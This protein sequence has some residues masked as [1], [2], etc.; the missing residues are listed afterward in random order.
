M[1]YEQESPFPSLGERILQEAEARA[2]EAVLATPRELL[3]GW[4]LLPGDGITLEADGSVTLPLPPD[5]LM[6]FCVR[7]S[8]WQ[9]AVYE[10]LPAGSWL[11]R[12][13]GSRWLGL[14]GVPERPLAFEQPAADGGKCLKL[15]SAGAGATDV[16]VTEGWY[17]PAPQITAAGE[18]EIPPAAYHKTLGLIAEAIRCG[19]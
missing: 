10:V 5:Y 2:A 18:I 8:G 14:R 19:A 15:F 13:Q 7:L 9:R 3:T 17:M 16:G 11:R 4:R 12:L 6:L 1:M